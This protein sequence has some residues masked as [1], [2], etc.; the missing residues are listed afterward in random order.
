MADPDDGID[1]ELAERGC[2][3][4]IGTVGPDGSP[5]ASRGWGL[6]LTPAT[7]SPVRLLLDAGDAVTLANLRR[8]G[9]GRVAITGADVVTLRSFQLKG[10][11]VAIDGLAGGI[12]GSAQ[13]QAE[14][15]ARVRRTMGEM[16]DITQQNAAMTEEA[17]AAARQLANEAVSLNQQV[18]RF[19]LDRAAAAPHLRAVG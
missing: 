14:G 1:R 3:L 6:T 15:L 4:V 9:D 5:H 12:A 2:A 16:D 18:G 17:T 10:R 11:V 13:E 19:R 7:A 8:E